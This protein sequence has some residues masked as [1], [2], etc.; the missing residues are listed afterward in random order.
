MLGVVCGELSGGYHLC[1]EQGR[2]MTSLVHSRLW[3]FGGIISYPRG[4]SPSLKILRIIPKKQ[5]YKRTLER[6]Y[7]ERTCVHTRIL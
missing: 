2:H 4:L 1:L 3:I 7:L 6:R 5:T